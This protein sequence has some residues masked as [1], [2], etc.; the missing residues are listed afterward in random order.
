MA[1]C[2][3]SAFDGDYNDGVFLIFIRDGEIPPT[4]PPATV[5]EPLIRYEYECTDN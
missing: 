3:S 1:N 5:P 2:I 4:E